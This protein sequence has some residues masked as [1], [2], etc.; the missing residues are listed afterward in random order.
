MENS[1]LTSIKSLLGIEADY[2]HFD[3][4]IIMHINSVFFILWQLGV[5]PESDSFSITDSSTTWDHYTLTNLNLNAVKSYV[6][7]KVRLLFDPPLSNALIQIIKDQI[8]EL[9]FRIMITVDPKPII[10]EEVTHYG[11]CYRE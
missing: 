8:T 3:S 10:V 7:L 11:R 1:I 9:E 5:N 2:T 4:D 6:Y